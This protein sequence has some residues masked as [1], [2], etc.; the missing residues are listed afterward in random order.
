L[1]VCSQGRPYHDLI[2][3]CGKPLRHLV[4]NPMLDKKSR[5]CNAALTGAGEDRTSRA[6]HRLLNLGVFEDNVSRFPAEL[7]Q[8]RLDPF[9][10]EG[11]DTPARIWRAD[12][13]HLAH[14]WMAD[15]CSTRRVAKSRQYTN[16][17]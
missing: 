13:G 11:G 1:R 16:D 4:I 5:T 7:Q 2:G 8:A 10:A 3:E 12:K 15:S 9:G 14:G 6:A 17:R